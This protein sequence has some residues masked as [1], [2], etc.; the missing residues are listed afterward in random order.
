MG[1]GARVAI[2]R[3]RA[4]R[5]WRRG[6]TS[7]RSCRRR[8]G[9]R[10]RRW[11]RPRRDAGRRRRG[12]GGGVPALGHA[13]GGR[14][15]GAARRRGRR[16]AWARRGR[17]RAG[18]RAASTTS[19]S[20]RGCPPTRW[21]RRSSSTTRS[22]RSSR[23]RSCCAASSIA[24]SARLRGR[25]LACAGLTLRLA[26]D[27]RGLDVRA[28]PIAAPTRD[29]A[30]LLQLVRLDLARR[31]PA[32][33]VVGARL[34]ALPARVRATQLDIL[35]PA[36]P[37]PDRLAATIARLAALVG[38]ENVGAPAL[39]DTLAR[40]GGRRDDVRAGA[41]RRLT[42][43]R[44]AC[45]LAGR[46]QTAAGTV[47]AGRRRA[48]VDDS[49]PAAAGG[50][51]GADRTAQGPTA[52]RG[53]D[54][55][56]RVLV[57]AG[58][59]RA[60]GRV[61]AGARE[62]EQAVRAQ[63]WDVHASDGAVYRVHQDRAQRPLVPRW[64]L[65]LSRDDAAANPTTSSCAAGRRSASS[66]ARRCP[67]IWS[68]RRRR[69]GHDALALADRDGVYGA[70]RF[71]A[72]ARKA[73]LRPIV[74]ADVTL[75]AGAA[76][77][78]LLVEDRRGYQ[79]LCRLITAAKDGRSKKSGSGRAPPRSARRARGRPDRARRARRRAPICRRSS[80]L[81]ART[82]SSWRCSATS[83]PTRR[84]ATATCWRRPSALGVGVVATNDVR[85]ATPA[86]R[87]VHDVLTCAR[88]KATVDEIGRRLA[89]ERRA[90]AQAAARDARAVPRPA[91][92]PCAPR[93]P[94]P[95]AARSRSPTSATR[96]PTT[97]SR[98]AR[99]SRATSRSS[100]GTGVA[101][102]LR[103][104]R[105]APAQGA[106]AARARAR[107]HRAPGAGRLLPGRLGHRPV[108]AVARDHGPGARLGGELG[109]L[110]R[111]RHHRRRSGAD[112]AAVRALPV[113]G[114]RRGRRQRRRSHAR[115]RS[116]S[117]VGRPARAGDPAR[118]RQ[119]RRA[120]RRHDRQRDHLPPAH[121]GARRGARARLLRGAARPHREPPAEVADG[122]RRAARDAPGGGGLPA[123]GAPHPPA[124]RGGARRCSTCR[125]TSASTRAAW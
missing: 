51:R 74:G 115:H 77:L 73:G 54:T 28:V 6:R 103:R 108:R 29:A 9:R 111:P 45:R 50:D 13:H 68:R 11:R 96:S 48:A 43:R 90:L 52:L 55:T 36:G 41:A 63:Y 87:I 95:S 70:P 33:A 121:G 15:G 71:F 31:P 5:G 14:R 35:R 92:A 120:R 88:E 2:A 57:A 3:R 112:G 46:G 78:L 107:H 16:C 105:P 84:T 113:R 123:D 47:S 82:A 81:R 8:P 38:P 67:R 104:R 101:L 100:P 93:A 59:Y 21:R 61:V 86:Q 91:R 17:A 60:V 79:N 116:R 18:W 98:P 64:L 94:S 72:A 49:A 24:R 117:A 23:W 110:L 30:T 76:P 42:R 32:R 22:T 58:P 125:A 83:T 114:A 89:P 44:T 109:R 75:A 118:L 19:R 4:W 7:W 66:T 62:T 27:P 25:S 106:P 39:E 124:R 1:L 85:Y 69:G 53:R 26:L 40:G 80:T 102:P 20:C 12:A 119:V 37:A 65:R 10:A 34:L 56:A 99:R 97:P 122:R